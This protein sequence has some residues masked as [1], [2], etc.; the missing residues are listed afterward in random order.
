VTIRS[1][2]DI[3]KFD[4]VK[5][6]KDFKE[7]LG[8]LPGEILVGTV[9]AFAGHKD[10]PTLLHAF[11]M[12]LGKIKNIKLCIVGDGPLKDKVEEMIQNLGISNNVIMPGFRKDIGKFLKSFDIFVLSSKKEGLGTSIID[13]LSVGLPVIA[14][15]A[16]GIPELIEN[17]VNGRLAP[18][19]SPIDLSKI[20]V[21]LIEDESARKRLSGKAKQSAINFSIEN[22]IAQNIELYKELIGK[23]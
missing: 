22:N 10:Y 5:T 18:I 16:G 1:G 13:A 17:D 12:A 9:A 19:K 2:A 14:T 21:E 23:N 15:E 6:D 3:H 11:S 7:K 8:V 4:N 20:I